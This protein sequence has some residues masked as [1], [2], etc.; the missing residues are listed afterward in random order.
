M[1]LRKALLICAACAGATALA[2]CL[3]TTNTGKK[4]SDELNYSLGCV[5]SPELQDRQRLREAID[6]LG[7][8]EE[9]QARVE[10][11]AYTQ[12]VPKSQLA[13]TL[14][15]SIDSDPKDRWGEKSYRYR[16]Q[17][18]DTL[19]LIAER[20]LGDA[21][22]FYS[23]AKYNGIENPTALSA[24]ET[25]RIPG[26]KKAVERIADTAPAPD[27]APAPPSAPVEAVVGVAENDAPAQVVQQAAGL[28][29]AEQKLSEAAAAWNAKDY[30]TALQNI[31]QAFELHPDNEIVVR[32][33][34]VS[35]GD[36]AELLMDAGDIPGARIAL[37]R[38]NEFAEVYGA[39]GEVERLVGLKAKVA[40]AEGITKAEAA[41]KNG[42]VLAA[43]SAYQ[44][45]VRAAPDNEAA[46]GKVAA[47]APDVADIYFQRGE[48][49]FL[50]EEFEAAEKAFS[51]AVNA[52]PDHSRAQLKL[53][54]VRGILKTLA[55]LGASSN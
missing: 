47:L 34:A 6:L 50:D 8:G 44:A 40:A 11:I 32:Q 5:K 41:E 4:P 19:S 20:H 39:A 22:L 42:D 14:L 9:C 46:V 38:A 25:I 54:E 29:T 52:K 30:F 43:F 21:M 7:R 15:W 35:Y 28:P 55:E 13:Q 48:E 2:G 45:V 36:H 18:R 23:L 3:E 37:R 26:E 12:A 49:A 33:G 1:A 17:S 31:E 51:D 16:V 53:E 10:L 24:G 27:D